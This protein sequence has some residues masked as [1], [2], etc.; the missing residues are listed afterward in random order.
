METGAQNE[1]I[2]FPEKGGPLLT[3]ETEVNWGS[4]STNERDGS[5]DGS[6]VQVQNIFFSALAALSTKYK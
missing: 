6:F 4:K 1:D 5:L 3:V 2:L